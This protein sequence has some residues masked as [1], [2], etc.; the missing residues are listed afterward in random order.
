[1]AAQRRSGNALKT[2]LNRQPRLDQLNDHVRP[3]VGTKWYDL[4]VVLLN[5]YNMLDIIKNNHPNDT[6]TCCTAMFKVW[7]QRDDNSSWSKLVNA[8]R[9]QS[10]AL[11]VLAG[12]VERMFETD[13][14]HEGSEGKGHSRHDEDSSRQ[15]ASTG[16]LTRF[17]EIELEFARM[18]N[19][20][21]NALCR[22]NTDVPSLIEQLQSIST[23]STKQVPLFDEN[24]FEK[25]PTIDELWKILSKFWNIFDYDILIPVVRLSKCV[26][27]EELLD[28][29]LARIDPAAI[30]GEDLVLRYRVYQVEGLLQPQLR[31]KIKTEQCNNQVMKKVKKIISRKFSL[32]E[33]SLYFVG[34]K[35]GCIELVFRISKATMS[36]L[37]TFTI[38]N[39]II[40][41]LTEQDIICLQINNMNIYKPPEM[42]FRK[43]KDTVIDIFEQ[44]FGTSTKEYSI[45]TLSQLHFA[46]NNSPQASQS[47]TWSVVD[48]VLIDRAK[49]FKMEA[50]WF[51]VF[52]T[53]VLNKGYRILAERKSD[54]SVV[55][56]CE[57]ENSPIGKQKV[58]K[59]WND[60]LAILQHSNPPHQMQ[61]CN[62]RENGYY[63]Y[64]QNLI[65]NITSPNAL[66]SQSYA[67]FYHTILYGTIRRKG[68][69][70]SIANFYSNDADKCFSLCVGVAQCSIPHQRFFNFSVL[71][72]PSHESGFVR[73]QLSGKSKMMPMRANYINEMK[74]IDLKQ[75]C[76]QNINNYYTSYFCYLSRRVENMADTICKEDSSIVI[77]KGLVEDHLRPLCKTRELLPNLNKSEEEY[78]GVLQQLQAKFHHLSG[79]PNKDVL[80]YVHGLNTS[81]KECLLRASQIACDIDFSGRVAVYSWPSIESLSCFQDNN[82]LDAA[83]QT[84]LDFLVMM[85]QSGGKLHIIAHS[86]ANLLLTRT[87]GSRLSQLEGKLGQ[88]I[89]ADADVEVKFF[90]ELYRNSNLAPGID[91][92]A[93]N[94]TVYYHPSDKVLLWKD[95]IHH[96]GLPIGGVQRRKIDCV[97]IGKCV[98]ENNSQLTYHTVPQMKQNTYADNA[99]IIKDM[100]AIINEGLE[101]YQRPH[102]KIACSCNTVKPD[103][104]VKQEACPKC[105]SNFEYVIDGLF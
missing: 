14:S 98:F 68:N 41:D 74:M 63:E 101:A 27:A 34:I 97:N 48:T 91:S 12:E 24:V 5:D 10:V 7:L 51:A 19:E 32:E 18:A 45:Q 15:G 25:I 11:N 66:S 92:I 30:E 78:L 75:F 59:Y 50:K 99:F 94:V 1:M 89:C 104:I 4:G 90:Q 72:S 13:T 33:Y 58:D 42:T 6:E 67:E 35:E 56:L 55:L 3:I 79:K 71:I 81:I 64:D 84:F 26:E 76:E 86:A 20:I 21:K 61:V 17:S 73:N 47:Y 9:A 23:V 65:S 105:N 53:V 39:S 49:I 87:T 93:D 77:R 96:I 80:L 43:I 38:T 31:V 29:F 60:I 28:Q 22:A 102:I 95:S 57:G 103:G 8:L 62:H 88:V 100:S 52:S 16:R 37:L 40:A 70:T 85:C 36:Y 54:Q 46:I 69:S 82:Q 44:V 83:M 2:G